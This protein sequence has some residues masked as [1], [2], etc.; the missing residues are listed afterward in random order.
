MEFEADPKYDSPKS[1][2]PDIAFSDQVEDDLLNISKSV[3][4]D[5]FPGE[6]EF[7]RNSFLED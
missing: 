7:L 2:F 4:G 1:L 5:D 6:P 3:K